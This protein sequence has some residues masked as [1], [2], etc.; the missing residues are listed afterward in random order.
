MQLYD[1][2][3][4][5]KSQE[6]QVVTSISPQNNTVR[7]CSGFGQFHTDK[8]GDALPTITIAAIFDMVANPQ[9]VDKSEA[10]WF[11]PSTAKTRAGATQ[12]AEGQYHAVWVDIDKHT[13]LERID[14]VLAELMCGY[15]VHSS[16]SSTLECQK[17]RVIIPLAEPLAFAS[18]SLLSEI[19]NDKFQAA[20]ITPDRATERANQLCYL[21]NRGEFYEYS[22]NPLAPKHLIE[23]FAGEIAT[24]QQVAIVVKVEQEKRKVVS[25]AKAMAWVGFNGLSPIDALKAE[26]PLEQAL[27]CYGYTRH[28]DRYLSPNSYSGIAGVT[29]KGDRWFSNHSSDS[30]I[31]K[32][33]SGG[34]AGDVFDLF[35]HYEH[36][37]DKKAAMNWNADITKANQ[38]AFMQANAPDTSSIDTDAIINAFATV[39]TQSAPT[40]DFNAVLDGDTDFQTLDLLKHIDDDQLIKRMALNVADVTE[41]PPST[42]LLVALSMFSGSACLGQTVCYTDGTPLPIGLYVCAEQPSGTAKSRALGIFQQPFTRIL[43]P[44]ITSVNNAFKLYKTTAKPDAA[45]LAL[46]KD[47]VDVLNALAPTT[48]ATPEA[49]E[50]GLIHSHG[51]FNLASSEQGLANSVFGYAYNP[52]NKSSTNNND[53][54]LNGFDGGVVKVGR[55]GRESYFGAVYGGVTLFAQ[56][57]SIDKILNAALGTGL[58]ERFL[59]IAE[60]HNLGKRNHLKDIIIDNAILSEY[61]AICNTYAECFN[62]T[63]TDL[64]KKYPLV[65][66]DV[67]WV[68]IKTFRQNVE[69]QL[70]NGKDYSHV[71][72]RGAA[73]KLEQQ[74]MKI[75]ANL[76]ILSG[77]GVFENNVIGSQHIT[78]AIYIARDLIKAMR[79]LLIVKGVMGQPAE[80][81]AVIAYLSKKPK[82]AG[83]TD[84]KNSLSRT[85]PFVDMTCSKKTA[86]GNTI[87][88]MVNLGLLIESNG[89]FLVK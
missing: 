32:S 7:L 14:S 19:I 2:T 30:A 24:K 34:T 6:L 29:V 27:A 61:T 31:G 21:P 52:S 65:I 48:N 37:G 50:I 68:R 69:P 15:A 39:P 20:G 64:S 26:Y 74:I 55:A 66:S 83:I 22:I 87:S 28:G 33:F 41:L 51:Y 11:I 63:P 73:G 67:D 16:K 58:S 17:W 89:V 85:K 82:G 35:V 44:K 9:N 70:A 88:E 81:E 1:S 75:A 72:L 53:I 12:K 57:G 54:L 79:H 45:T 62:G 23:L 38:T 43:E 42:V 84:M 80:F 71:S 46:Y 5:D 77:V 8:N 60:P 47:N 78:S 4:S 3:N 86:V 18:W 10:Q 36:S 56:Q 76:H 49:I 40:S 25:L 59:F 13:T